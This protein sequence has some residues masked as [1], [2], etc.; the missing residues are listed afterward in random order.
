MITAHPD[1][2]SPVLGLEAPGAAVASPVSLQPSHDSDGDIE[3]L[4]NESG[5]EGSYSEDLEDGDS[6]DDFDGNAIELIEELAEGDSNYLSD[7]E[8]EEEEEEVEV[9]GGELGDDPD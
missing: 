2:V 1:E 3:T 5:H 6:E 4:E 9:E 7:M 8:E